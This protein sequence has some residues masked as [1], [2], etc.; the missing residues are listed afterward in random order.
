MGLFSRKKKAQR[1]AMDLDGIMSA[2]QPRPG[3]TDMADDTRVALSMYYGGMAL[4]TMIDA[5]SAKEDITKYDWRRKTA[6][7]N[8]DNYPEEISQSY[9][10]AI[11]KAGKIVRSFDTDKKETPENTYLDTTYREWFD[12]EFAAIS[13]IIPETYVQIS[14]P[15]LSDDDNGKLISKADEQELGMAPETHII[16]PQFVQNFTHD[17]F[18]NLETITIK[19]GNSEFEVYDDTYK[20]TIELV[21]DADKQQTINLKKQEEHGFSMCP[22]VRV[23]WRENK[24]YDGE[25]KPGQ[26]MMHGIVKRSK[27]ALTLKSMEMENMH[28]H[29]Y[30]KEAAGEETAKNIIE[31][32]QGADKLT[33]VGKA[34]DGSTEP[35]P[36]YIQT[37]VKPIEVLE[38][39]NYERIPAIMYHMARLRDRYTQKTQ[40]GVAKA[41]DMVPEIQVLT[42]I[43]D[44]W[45]KADMRILKLL[46]DGFKLK[47]A[48]PIAE[49]PKSFQVKSVAEILQEIAELTKIMDD[50]SL[51]QSKTANEIISERLYKGLLP[52]L[53]DSQYAEILKEIKEY[54]P[55]PP[56]E[57]TALAAGRPA[58]PNQSL[59]AEEAMEQ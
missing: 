39:I 56:V 14:L 37:D 25:P 28:F 32:G 27:G 6:I 16:Y 2:I 3:F 4:D 9:I 40:S 58:M 43:A 26:A 19:T 35:F 1:V 11:K 5:F 33:I 54:K 13:L 50:S 18:G 53:T 48:S 24:V 42:S 15:S 49:Y 31:Q 21:I 55:L 22:F 45:K 8:Y 34:S 51:S 36:S 57:M 44:F 17:R 23:V 59:L 47:N 41:F 7:E 29:L 20:Y 52:D 10:E 38:R 30:P 46:A 12:K